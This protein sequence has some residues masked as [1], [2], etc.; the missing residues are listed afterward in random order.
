MEKTQREISAEIQAEVAQMMK[1]I[2]VNSLVI[3][4]RKDKEQ[5]ARLKEIFIDGYLERAD[6][7]MEAREALEKLG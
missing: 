2:V 5:E 3:I 4:Q 1:N 7:N 6:I